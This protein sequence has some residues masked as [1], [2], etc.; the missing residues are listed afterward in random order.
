MSC[1]RLI[2]IIYAGD[3]DEKTAATP[4]AITSITATTTVCQDASYWLTDLIRLRINNG[5]KAV[6][7]I[8]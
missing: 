3:G 4:A 6:K 7:I 2:S 8:H 5:C 1:C